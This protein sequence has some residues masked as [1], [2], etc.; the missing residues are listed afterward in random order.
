MSQGG[1][2]APRLAALASANKDLFAGGGSEWTLQ[3]RHPDGEHWLVIGHFPA[4]DLALETAKAFVVA[5][6]G[7]A[8]DFRVQRTKAPAD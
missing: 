1:P 6:Y 7:T 8:E 2:N 5:N 3:H 4:K